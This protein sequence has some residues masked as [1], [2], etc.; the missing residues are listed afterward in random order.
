VG[1]NGF[2][3]I[4]RNEAALTPCYSGK[5]ATQSSLSRA[6]SRSVSQLQAMGLLTDLSP[7][8]GAVV[9]SPSLAYTLPRPAQLDRARVRSSP[10]ADPEQPCRCHACRTRHALPDTAP[11][12]RR[13]SSPSAA[14]L[15]APPGVKN[16]D[17]I[18]HSPGTDR[19]ID[20]LAS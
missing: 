18:I 3:T 7:W 13:D 6:P 15:T 14:A 2:G 9:A 12:V 16:V 8:I 10:F 5:K 11:A 20:D 4:I 17:Q 1:F 19:P